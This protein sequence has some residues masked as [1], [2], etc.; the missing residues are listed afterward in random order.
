MQH[1]VSRWVER[2]PG[3][4]EEVA[5]KRVEIRCDKDEHAARLEDPLTFLQELYGLIKVLNY[6]RGDNGIEMT[7][8]EDLIRQGSGTRV[9]SVTLGSRDSFRVGVDSD[10]I[11][12]Q[13]TK[14]RH[15]V[16]ATAP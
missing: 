6:V 2:R 11:P 10:R 14:A 3:L 7:G 4:A 13:P 15:Q 16:P 1:H 5:A 9:Q 12:A 8:R